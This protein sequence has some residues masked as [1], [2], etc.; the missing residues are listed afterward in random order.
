MLENSGTEEFPWVG[1]EDMV[2]RS[3]GSQ[4][5]RRRACRVRREWLSSN[6]ARKGRLLRNSTPRLYSEARVVTPAREPGWGLRSGYTVWAQSIS[7]VLSS[8][9]TVPDTQLQKA[10]SL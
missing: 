5:D 8:H 6:E 2:L 10:S 3:Q 9:R 1:P 7:S 4:L